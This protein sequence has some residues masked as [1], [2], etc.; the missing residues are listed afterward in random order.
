MHIGRACLALV[1]TFSLTVAAAPSERTQAEV[2]HLLNY[3][4]SS[5]CKFSRNGKWYS[6]EPA[7]QHLQMKYD[8]LMK[9]ELLT[10]TESFIQLGATSSS[11][12]GKPYLVQ[13]AGSEPIASAHWFQTELAKFR[14]ANPSKR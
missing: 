9:K 10:S 6:A 2:S 12:S 14:A 11:V 13:C 7:T 8:Y 1:A 3:L 5:G 4:K